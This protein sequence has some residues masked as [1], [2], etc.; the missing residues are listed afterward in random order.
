MCLYKHSNSPNIKKSIFNEKIHL[1]LFEIKKL[2]AKNGHIFSGLLRPWDTFVN[3]GFGYLDYI[4]K[5]NK[6][7]S[8][9]Y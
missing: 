3:S 1:Y 6:F 7:V 5:H 2:S 4:P 9:T 8:K